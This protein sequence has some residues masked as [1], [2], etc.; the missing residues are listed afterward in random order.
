M[1]QVGNS[2]DKKITINGARIK[3]DN[4]ILDAFTVDKVTSIALEHIEIE[5][6]KIVIDFIKE[7]SNE[8]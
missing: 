8:A 6:P 4:L 2:N 5:I 3:N 7:Y 1:D